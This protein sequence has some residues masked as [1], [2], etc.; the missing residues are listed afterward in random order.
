MV[1]TKRNVGLNQ[2]HSRRPK[3]A[4]PCYTVFEI[5]SRRSH[6]YN[7]ATSTLKWRCLKRR[8]LIKG[9][10]L[11]RSANK[12]EVLKMAC[13]PKG[14]RLIRRAL[15]MACSEMACAQNV[16]CSKRRAPKKACAQKGA[17]LKRNALINQ[18]NQLMR[19]F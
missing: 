3:K 13:A 7:G 16:V 2:K 8:A 9:V 6:F 11:K 12:K 10:R 17:P 1:G 18:N 19:Q 14:V 4:S 5:T 15:K